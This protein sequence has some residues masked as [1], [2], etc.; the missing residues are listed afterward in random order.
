MFELYIIFGTLVLLII[1]V[2]IIVIITNKSNPSPKNK[3]EPSNP[4]LQK[5]KDKMMAS[6]YPQPSAPPR[7]A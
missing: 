5:N 6:R 3:Y 2:I 7:L 4:P 1:I